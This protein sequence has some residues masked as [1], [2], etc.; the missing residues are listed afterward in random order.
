MSHFFI[1]R[2]NFAIVI[3]IVMVLA[4]LLAM[5]VI[6]VAQYPDITP[7]QVQVSATYSGANAQDVSNSVAAP[8]E[9]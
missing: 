8:V 5:T 7:P 9:A 6:P 2:P 4:G 3:S 1:D